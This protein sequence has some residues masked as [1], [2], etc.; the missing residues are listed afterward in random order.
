[1]KKYLLAF[2]LTVSA[3][4]QTAPYALMPV[5]RQQFFDAT[6]KPLTGG[7][8]YTYIAGTTTPQATYTDASGAIQNTNPIVLDSG[9]FATVWLGGFSYKV[10]AQNS[11]GQQQWSVDNVSDVGQLLYA[12]AVLL[13]P[14]ASALQTIIGP[15]G[16]NYF[17][18][19]TLHTTSPGVRVSI[20]DP[21]STLD[22]LINPPGLNTTDPAIAAQNYQIPDPGTAS[23]NFVLSPGPANWVASTTYTIGTS[24]AT[25]QPATSNPC[26]FTF[27]ATVSGTSSGINPIFSTMPCGSSASIIHDNGI[28]WT[29]QGL[30]VP[31]NGLDCTKGGITCIRNS[32][33]Y[34]EAAGCNN[35]IA[36]MGWDTFGANSPAPICIAGTNIQKGVLAFPSAATHLQ[37]AIGTGAAATTCTTSY[38]FGT[39]ASHFLEVEIGVDG[40]RTVS[41]ATDGTNAYTRAISV[42]NGNYDIEIWYFNGSST[43]MPAGTTLTV[44]LSAAA[45]CALNWKEYDGILTSG[46]L[47]KTTSSSGTGTLSNSGNTATPTQNVELLLGAMVANGAPTITA[48]TPNYVRHTPV[49]QSTNLTIASEGIIQQ[50][51]TPEAATF[52]IGASSTWAAAIAT[53]KINVAGNVTAQRQIVLPAYFLP[54]VPINAIL[55]WQA[56]QAPAG[57]QGFISMGAAIV[58]TQDGFADDP[59]YNA[60]VVQSP[61]V[62]PSGLNLITTSQFNSLTATGCAPTNLMHFELQRLR[63]SSPDNFEGYVYVDGAGLQFGINQ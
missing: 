39:T 51:A 15:L 49:S 46:M 56:P 28:T 7:L 57:L 36:A 31:T 19:N 33:T 6:G 34:F 4:A 25:I 10:V 37:E 30:I 29:S 2:L 16:A 52:N 55:K 63:Y 12:K 22:T 45:D 53:F 60:A 5:P 47:D 11:F 44:T 3:L 41:S 1:M 38:V 58:C 61:N 23:A 40:G 24:A 35:T 48:G 13:T 62:N 26:H 54:T 43:A 18:Q 9:G 59:S 20:L 14:T 42:A 27:I 50:A 32:Y 8:L 21:A 17:Q